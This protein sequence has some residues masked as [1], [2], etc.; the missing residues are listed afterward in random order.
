MA[1]SMPRDVDMSEQI[2]FSLMTDSF[3]VQVVG[4]RG[5]K[6]AEHCISGAWAMREL[7]EQLANE[8]PDCMIAMRRVRVDTPTYGTADMRTSHALGGH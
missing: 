7:A 5:E 6:L 1:S 4:S 3:V 8:N 2:S